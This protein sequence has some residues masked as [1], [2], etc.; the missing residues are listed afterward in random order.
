MTQ[1][2]ESVAAPCDGRVVESP[3]KPTSQVPRP[4]MASGGSGPTVA[5]SRLA[6]LLP[7]PMVVRHGCGRSR[8]RRSA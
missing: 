8:S 3:L 6:D 4:V 1:A 5:R 2:N 7:N